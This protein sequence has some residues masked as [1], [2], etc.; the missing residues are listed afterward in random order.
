[1]VR[2]GRA[3]GY[4][5]AGKLT[6]KARNTARLVL[7]PLLARRLL[8]LLALSRGGPLPTEQP[9]GGRM[10]LGSAL[11][12]V[13]QR[14]AACLAAAAQRLAASRDAVPQHLAAHQQAAA[15]NQR[16]K[17]AGENVGTEDG[18]RICKQAGAARRG[19]TAHGR[20]TGRLCQH[21]W[22]PCWQCGWGWAQERCGAGAC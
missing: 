14:P 6:S 20:R 21:A 10:V 19:S 1:M 2:V 16:A 3:T 9:Q 17:N 18:F 12:A 7:P 5:G 11:D 13:A 8:L 4:S 15:H 22:F